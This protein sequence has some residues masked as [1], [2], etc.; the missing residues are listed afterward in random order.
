MGALRALENPVR[1]ARIVGYEKNTLVLE[2][3][4]DRGR[5]RWD[6]RPIYHFEIE[7]IRSEFKRNWRSALKSLIG[8]SIGVY[9][10]K[11]NPA[12]WRRW[13]EDWGVWWGRS[14][15][16]I[17]ARVEQYGRGPTAEFRYYILFSDTGR[18]IA[19]GDA[20]NPKDG[21]RKAVARAR[22]ILAR[23]KKHGIG[24]LWKAP[25]R[26]RMM[27]NPARW[28]WKKDSFYLYTHHGEHPRFR[29]TLDGSEYRGKAYRWSIWRKSDGGLAASGDEGSAREAQRAVERWQGGLSLFNPKEPKWQ[30]VKG[31]YVA[32]YEGFRAKIQ[33]SPAYQRF[34]YWTVYKPGGEGYSLDQ[35]RAW[36]LSSVKFVAGRML[37]RVAQR[38]LFN[39][40]RWKPKLKWKKTSTV[41][42]EAKPKAGVTL[43]VVTEEPPFKFHYGILVGS[44]YKI[45]FKGRANSLRKAQAFAEVAY[46]KRLRGLDTDTRMLFNAVQR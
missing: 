19:G 1:S 41:T 38:T 14:F 34:Y 22:D 46:V 12:L 7:R 33:R 29:A 27:F 17:K 40:L 31:G 21:Q 26:A 10:T 9:P 4:T 16:P 15:G 25:P 8:Q 13:G 6:V 32:D 28:T 44:K 18:W 2:I 43:M 24:D 3:E 36:P 20:R 11:L 23:I 37:M 30:R 42:W 39:P 5:Y 45:V 35:G